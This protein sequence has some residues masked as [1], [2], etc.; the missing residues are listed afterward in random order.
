[1]NFIPRDAIFDEAEFTSMATRDN[2]SM[3]CCKAPHYNNGLLD[4]IEE[5]RS[6][7]EVGI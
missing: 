1:M 2:G 6:W 4:L 5:V 7:Y 3:A